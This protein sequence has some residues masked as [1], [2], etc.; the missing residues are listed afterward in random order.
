MTTLVEKLAPQREP[1][2]RRSNARLNPRRRKAMAAKSI[3]N[4]NARSRDSPTKRQ[5]DK[6]RVLV[7]T[8]EIISPKIVFKRASLFDEDAPPPP[9]PP[10][11]SPLGAMRR[12]RAVKKV[13]GVSNEQLEQFLLQQGIQDA[14]TRACD[15]HETPTG[16]RLKVTDHRNGWAGLVVNF[17]ASTRSVLFQGPNRSARVATLR[18]REQALS[19]QNEFLLGYSSSG[20]EPEEEAKETS[21]I[22]EQAGPEEPPPLPPMLEYNDTHTPPKA[23][24]DAQVSGA[25]SGLGKKVPCNN[26]GDGPT[27]KR[28][29]ARLSLRQA[30]EGAS[31]LLDLIIN[32]DSHYSHFQEV[33]RCASMLARGRAHAASQSLLS[34]GAAP[35]TTGR[36]ADMHPAREQGGSEDCPPPP[37]M[38]EHSDTHTQPKAEA[39]V[40]VNGALSGLGKKV[41]CN[42][43]GDG[44]TGLPEITDELMDLCNRAGIEEKDEGARLSLRQAAE[45]ASLL[46]NLSLN[47]DFEYSQSQE[48]IPCFANRIT[49][50][51]QNHGERLDRTLTP[52]CAELYVRSRPLAKLGPSFLWSKQLQEIVRNGMIALFYNL[53]DSMDAFERSGYVAA[54]PFTKAIMHLC[55]FPVECILPATRLTPASG[56]LIIEYPDGGRITISLGP[57]PRTDSPAATLSRGEPLQHNDLANTAGG[58]CPEVKG[59]AAMLTMGRSRAARQI[60]LSNGAAPRTKETADIMTDMHPD[61][62]EGCSRRPLAT[63]GSH[64]IGHLSHKKAC[65]MINN[66]AGVLE[67][68]I[69]PLGWATNY[70]LLVRGLKHVNGRRTPIQTLARLQQMLMG[71][72]RFI[73]DAAAF[74]LTVGALAALSKVPASRNEELRRQGLK[75]KIRPVNVGNTFMKGAYQ[76]MRTAPSAKAANESTRPIQKGNGVSSGG[77]K[78]VATARAA[79]ESGR[80]L[81]TDDCINGFNALKRSAVMD[82]VLAKHPKA[83][84]IFHKYYGI[85]SV[86]FFMY[87]DADGN[88]IVRAIESREGT[89]MGCPNGGDGFCQTAGGFVFEPMQELYP[90]VQHEAQVDDCLKIWTGPQDRTDVV[91]WET[92]YDE[93]AT[94]IADFDRHA[95]P[96]GIERNIGKGKIVV[97]PDA[98]LPRCATRSNGIT[99]NV[100]KDGM[101]VSGAPVGTPE[102]I[103]AA[104]EEKLAEAA[105]KLNSIRLFGQEYPGM[106][107]KMLMECGNVLLDYFT[108]NTPCEPTWEVIERFDQEVV[109]TLKGILVLSTATFPECS[110]KR[111]DRAIQM[112][113][114][115]VNVA[116]CQLTPLTVKGPAG[117]L[118]MLIAVSEAK[119]LRPMRKALSHMAGAA[120]KRVCDHL[121]IPFIH[122]GH[123]LSSF[124]PATADAITRGP[125]AAQTLRSSTKLGVQGAIVGKI[126]EKRKVDFM[127]QLSA[128]LDTKVVSRSDFIHISGVIARSQVTRVLRAPAWDK[129]CR[130]DALDLRAYFL[131]HF[132]LPQPLLWEAVGDGSK[133]Y[134]VS[135]C[136]SHSIKK[137]DRFLLDACGDH[138]CSCPGGHRARYGTHT[139]VC[140]AIFLMAEEAGCL[141][142]MEPS[143]ATLMGLSELECKLKFPPKANAA[144]EKLQQD[145]VNTDAMLLLAPSVSPTAR[146]VLRQMRANYIRKLKD[147]AEEEG[148]GLRLDLDIQFP[149][150][151]RRVGTQIWG[152]VTVVHSSSS[153]RKKDSLSFFKDEAAATITAAQ[154]GGANPYDAV[155]SPAVREA[156]KGKQKKYA[157]MMQLAAKQTDEKQ[158]VAVPLMF[159]LVLTHMGEIGPELIRLI[160]FFATLLKRRAAEGLVPQPV[161]LGR[162]PADFSARFRARCKDRLMAALVRG[163]GRQLRSVGFPRS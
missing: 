109:N 77:E 65:K 81:H 130:V 129:H 47:I 136:R 30:D 156:T 44:P 112:A 36:M 146:S 91:A 123:A 142:K 62:G 12:N 85:I 8:R 75:P 99:I 41:P 157:A 144:R 61:Y 50:L 64:D 79:Y 132:N 2:E 15:W 140:R 82:G 117:F 134:G 37:P 137:G 151:G 29:G 25:L 48:G 10:M 108:K 18:L 152:D 78:I 7:V 55:A 33:R 115:S 92:F 66:K 35:L 97:P 158:R 104:A 17:Y 133:D 45:A 31:A 155:P 67:E 43:M 126:M 114:L 87:V 34:N 122:P 73:P 128:D 100:V 56:D 119:G 58:V 39:D 80:I 148:K 74:L 11:L 102:Y 22:K 88:R 159:P 94:Y 6:P 26:M 101:M 52:L 40:Q 9:P 71:K 110:D 57:G 27:E 138:V 103:Q 63:D 89:R 98:P 46:N 145:V 28:D 19:W 13:A 105:R 120:Y 116:G 16:L 23:E 154:G 163:W 131:Y 150:E 90:R 135:A 59:C 153:T 141:T 5:A 143:T 72:A 42:D 106:G 160:E 24:A 149:D 93:I 161:L 70:M 14:R 68:S 95:N 127:K 83:H 162:T 107:I 111:M 76:L 53:D 147:L 60:L 54:L 84:A 125:F 96:I 20:S 49:V 118:A 3:K 21:A 124:L 113:R 4:K 32:I 121:L 38:P 51:E 1:Q 86:V 139:G 69:D